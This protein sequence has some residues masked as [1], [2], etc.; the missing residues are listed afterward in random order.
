MAVAGPGLRH[1]QPAR[2]LEHVPRVVRAGADPDHRGRQGQRDPRRH[3]RRQAAGGRRAEPRHQ[4]PAHAHRAGAGQAQRRHDRRGQPAARGRPDAGSGT[5]RRSAGLVGGGTALADHFLQIRV[6]GDLALFQA[7]G[8]LLVE[9]GAVDKDFLDAYTE[10]FDAYAAGLAELD[11]AA[12]ERGHRAGPGP[13]RDHRPAVRRL[14]G[15]DRVLGDGPDAAAGRRCRPSARSSTC[16]C[17]GAWSAGPGAGLC[18]VRG[19]SNVQGDRTMGIVEHPPAWA[20]GA[21]RRC[22][23]SPCRPASG[24]DTVDAIRAM[25]DGRAAVFLGL[26]G[27]F[28]A[29]TPDTAVTE[30]APARLRADR[31]HLDQA[32]PLARAARAPRR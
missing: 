17:C 18:P 31:A 20:A 2:L 24:F 10:G 8:S 27:N 28:A 13:D 14:A 3:P 15:D 11:W 12:V 25:R 21:G 30:A 5:R 6:G 29:A 22:S 26:G 32:Q 7:I 19:H 1:Q 4:P 23:A 16:S 9:W